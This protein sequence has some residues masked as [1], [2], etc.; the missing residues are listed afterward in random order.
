MVVHGVLPVPTIAPH[1]Q[2]TLCTIFNYLIINIYIILITILTV[3]M[4]VINVSILTISLHPVVY[5]SYFSIV[6]ST[7]FY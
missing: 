3:N 2:F 4:S 1:G 6:Y 5:F 7:V